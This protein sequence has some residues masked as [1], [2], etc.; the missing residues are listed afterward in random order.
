MFAI[1][2]EGNIC[3]D[4]FYEHLMEVVFEIALWYLYIDREEVEV[5][6]TRVYIVPS[7]Y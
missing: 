7:K 4:F 2:Y 5:V 1:H 3:E 6:V